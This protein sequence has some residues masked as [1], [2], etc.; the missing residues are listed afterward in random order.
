M[1]FTADQ[2]AKAREAKTAEELIAFAKA[3]GIEAAEE[4]IRARFA[5]MHR[6]GEIADKEL[7]NVAGGCGAYERPA[8]VNVMAFGEGVYLCPRCGRNLL[9][10]P[11]RADLKGDMYY[12]YYCN[13]GDDSHYFRYYFDENVWTLNDD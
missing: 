3:E 13:S 10:L 12:P 4:E 1:K 8:T 11:S 9:C 6:E 5:A 7:D 2:L